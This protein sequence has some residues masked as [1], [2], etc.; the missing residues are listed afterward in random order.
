MFN[1]PP[2]PIEQIIQ[3]VR[4]REEIESFFPKDYSEE[5]IKSMSIT[6]TEEGLTGATFLVKI[7][8]KK[9][10]L[11]FLDM[12]LPLSKTL[13]EMWISQVASEN[14]VGPKVLDFDIERR[15]IF[16]EYFEGAHPDTMDTKNPLTVSALKQLKQFHQSLSTSPFEAIYKRISDANE[17][18]ITIS[19]KMKQALEEVKIIEQRLKQIRTAPSLCHGDFHTKNIIFSKDHSILIDWESSGFGYPYYDLA[20]LTYGLEFCDALSLFAH[21]LERKPSK[22]EETEFYLLRTIVHISIASNRLVKGNNTIL[23]DELAE[24]FLSEINSSGSIR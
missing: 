9:Y 2:P 20:K 21:Y 22:E 11:K 13:Q 3:T 12:K 1:P 4:C 8:Q 5:E 14:G 16:M 23:V 10:V 17:K 7:G 6:P 19:P 15:A 18:N 24:K